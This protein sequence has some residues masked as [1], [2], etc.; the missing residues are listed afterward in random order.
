MTD[1]KKLELITSNEMDFL[2]KR[3][4]G[5]HLALLYLA[6]AMKFLSIGI[7]RHARY[8]CLRALS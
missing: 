3:Y 2:G 6:R 1:E 7:L 5:L 8:F 4:G